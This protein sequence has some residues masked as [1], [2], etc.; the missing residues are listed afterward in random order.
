MNQQQTPETVY[1][2]L[3]SGKIVALQ[4]PIP[5]ACEA[6]VKRG[7]GE[8]ENRVPPGGEKKGLFPFLPMTYSFQ[9]LLRRLPTYGGHIGFKCTEVS[10]N[11]LKKISASLKLCITVPCGP[12]QIPVETRCYGV[13]FGVVVVE[14]INCI[15]GGIVR[16]E[17]W[18]E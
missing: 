9:C 17:I 12:L 3:F 1:S 6:G 15:C 7:G 10:S 13:H 16:N 4:P 2:P 8:E 5:V 14:L 18:K 11:I